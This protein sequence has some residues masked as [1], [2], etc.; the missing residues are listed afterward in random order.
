MRNKGFLVVSALYVFLAVSYAITIK[1]DT[2]ITPNFFTITLNY[3]LKGFFTIPVWYLLFKTLEDRPLWKKVIWHL[4]LL[5]PFTWIWVKAYYTVCDY[6]DLY[7]LQGARQIWDY[8]LTGLF[9]A[10]QFGILHIF[11]YYS[12]V[13]SKDLIIAQQDQLRLESELTALKAQLNPHFLYNVFNTINASIPTGAEQTRN[14][15]AKLSDLFRYQLKASNEALVSL[16]EELDFI[17]KY[18]DLEKER[19]GERLHYLV[20]SE[21]TLLHHKIPPLLIQPIVE[22]AIKHGISPLIS[23]GTV[24]IDIKKQGNLL[25]FSVRDTGVGLADSA[26]KE[27]INQG[28]GLTNTHKRLIKMYGQGLTLLDNEPSGLEVNFSIDLE[29]EIR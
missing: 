27:A 11:D 25:L 28:I 22:N 8:Y 14:M 18:L 24:S 4:A 21:R 3:G 2:G 13:Q 6:F 20:N 15:V 23:G 9:Y 19:F 12:K 7:Y 1:V 29:K 5:P 16:N 10:I 17:R 26:K